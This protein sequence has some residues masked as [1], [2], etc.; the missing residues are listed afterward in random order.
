MKLHD[1]RNDDWMNRTQRIMIWLALL[2]SEIA[3]IV[4]SIHQIVG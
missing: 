1:S 4:G 2:T 3:T